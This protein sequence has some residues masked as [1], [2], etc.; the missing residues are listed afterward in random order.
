MHCRVGVHVHKGDPG[1]MQSRGLTLRAALK[2][3]ETGEL[4]ATN[5]LVV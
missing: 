1:L 4:K 5:A 3:G 2:G